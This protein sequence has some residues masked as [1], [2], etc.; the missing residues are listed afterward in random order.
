MSRHPLPPKTPAVP[1]APEP[2][3]RSLV[4]APRMLRAGVFV[5]SQRNRVA[6][7]SSWKMNNLESRWCPI[8]KGNWIAGFRG[9]VA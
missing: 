9:K 4:A 1:A 7:C 6:M 5:L 3:S 2:W 8:F